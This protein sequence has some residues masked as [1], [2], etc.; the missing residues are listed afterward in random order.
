MLADR[1]NSWYES[2]I[3]TIPE[4]V[5]LV[6]HAGPIR[7][8][9]SKVYDTPLEEAFNLYAVDYGEVIMIS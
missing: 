4:K 3:A 1:V 2:L 9:L 8:I 5:I 7:T 6:T